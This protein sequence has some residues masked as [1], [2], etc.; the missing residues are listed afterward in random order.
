MKQPLQFKKLLSQTLST[1][2]KTASKIFNLSSYN[3]SNIQ[4]SVLHHSTKFTWTRSGSLLNYKNDLSKFTKKIQLKE[5]FNDTECEDESIVRN[6]STRKFETKSR[7]LSLIINEIE[8]LTP[9]L[10][11][12]ESNFTQE[13]SALQSLKAN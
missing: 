2:R 10:I 4:L 13:Y 5:I 11:S 3:F 1:T 7:E 9:N 12:Y 8:N 6:K